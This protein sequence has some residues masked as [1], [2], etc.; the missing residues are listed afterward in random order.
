MNIIFD[1]DGTLF[2]SGNLA[3]V[4]FK[5]VFERLDLEAPSDK[6]LISTLGYPIDEIWEMLIPEDKEKRALAKMLM[7]EVENEMIKEGHGQLFSDVL[8][9]L[10]KLKDKGHTLMILSNCDKPYLDV[11]SERFGFDQYFSGLYCAG[12]YNKLTKSQIL[13]Q[14]LAGDKNAVMI[15]DRFHDIQ[16]GRDNYIHTIWCNYGYSDEI[17]NADYEV[18]EFSQIVDII[19]QIQG[20]K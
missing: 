17:L 6:K 16:A 12:M 15:G 11:I 8:H 1:L 3:V 2:S 4:A 7:E 5:K 20:V 9:S 14:L 13:T 19:D 18:K 10:K